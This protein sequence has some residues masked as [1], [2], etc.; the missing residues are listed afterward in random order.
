MPFPKK[1]KSEFNATRTKID[2][3]NFDSIREGERYIVLK[4]LE[5]KGVIER[6]ELQPRYDFPIDGAKVRYT[7]AKKKASR[8]KSPSKAKSASK[9]KP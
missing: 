7:S 2:G 1:R 6:L 4:D 5:Q 8:K 9:K 3:H